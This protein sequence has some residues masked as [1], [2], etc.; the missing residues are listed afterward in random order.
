VRLEPVWFG[1]EKGNAG[2][3]SDLK[4]RPDRATRI[5]FLNALQES[6]GDAGSYRHVSRCDF[7]FDSASPNHL[8]Q[9][10]ESFQALTGQA[11]DWFW[12]ISP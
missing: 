1:F 6:S 11:A 8:C 5:S 7:P 3:G 10:F 9:Q 2:D 12:Y 4:D